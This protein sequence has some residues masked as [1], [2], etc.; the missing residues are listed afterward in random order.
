MWRKKRFWRYSII[1][2]CVGL[3]LGIAVVHFVL[4]QG[5][6]RPRRYLA[7]NDPAAFQH[8]IYPSDYNT[9]F[10]TVHFATH[11]SL[12]LRGYFMPAK[13]DTAYGTIILLHG[14]S[15]CKEQQLR[16]AAGYT[17]QGWNALI[18]DGRAHGE[19]EGRFCTYGAYEKQDLSS[20]VRWVRA[21]HPQ[22]LIGVQGISLGGA[23]TLQTLAIE[24]EIDFGIVESTFANLNDIVFDYQQRLTGLGVR[25]LSTYVLEQAANIAHFDPET[26]SPLQAAASIHQPIFYAH[27]T[28]DKHISFQYGQAIFEALASKDKVFYPI[29]GANHYNQ[30]LIGG[31]EYL[32]AMHD[33]ITD[34]IPKKQEQQ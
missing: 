6:I 31:P 4:P 19:S 26:V 16:A 11:D 33:F 29:E 28:Q 5:I 32:Q 7:K 23:I 30:Y 2:V 9:P 25:L 17:K 14:I 27:G 15:G 34:Q 12:K 8:K 3:L 22:Q 1:L 10:D 20:I 21:K 13:S 24:P 18:F